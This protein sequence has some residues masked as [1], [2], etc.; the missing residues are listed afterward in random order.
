MVAD[1]VF[2]LVAVVRM[3]G[4]EPL[5]DLGVVLGALILVVDDQPDGGP[6]GAPLEHARQDLHPIRFPA[7]GGVA[8]GAGFAP[9]QVVLQ[10]RLGDG[11][12]GRAAVHDTAD[13]GAVALAEACDDEESTYGIP[14]HTYAPAVRLAQPVFC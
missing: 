7:L 12:P 8:A 13:S 2:L 1:A 6:G 11:Q 4:A 14:G 10:V 9:V 5:L 3:A